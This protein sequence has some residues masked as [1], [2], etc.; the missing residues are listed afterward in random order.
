VVVY[1]GILAPNEE[2]SVHDNKRTICH[3]SGNTGF[4]GGLGLGCW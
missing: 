1:D 2:P 4:G 3:L